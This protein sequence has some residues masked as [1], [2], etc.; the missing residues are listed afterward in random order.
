M[1]ASPRKRSSKPR[2]LLHTCCGPCAAAVLEKLVDTYEVACFFYNPNIH[3]EAEY[4]LRIDQARELARRLAV[5]FTDGEYD[6]HQWFEE[7]SGLEEEPEGGRRCEVCFRIRLGRTAKKAKE[8]GFGAFATTLAISP[9]KDTQVIEKV[10]QEVSRE[11]GIPFL[12]GDWKKGN[13]FKRSVELSKEH[14]L[15]RQNYCGCEYSR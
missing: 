13:G 4:G 11:V 12:S 7:I 14:G 5:G 15:Y 6:A 8:M 3:P 9:H 1:T 10:G 2:L